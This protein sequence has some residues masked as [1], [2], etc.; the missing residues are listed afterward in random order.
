MKDHFKIEDVAPEVNS[1][2]DRVRQRFVGLS[3]MTDQNEWGDLELFD[4]IADSLPRLI[5]SSD[6]GREVA[7]ALE[8]LKRANRP[9]SKEDLEKQLVLLQRFVEGRI[10][11]IFPSVPRE[12]SR[13]FA[14][15]AVNA[16]TKA[17][18]L[19]FGGLNYLR[20]QGRV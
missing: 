12:L 14:I 9:L 6:F 7:A 8:N 15:I 20:D 3:G 11:E 5:S 16:G 1:F 4:Q 19:A 10:I 13:S 17:I 2:R 18:F